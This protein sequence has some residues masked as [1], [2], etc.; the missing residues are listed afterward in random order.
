MGWCF[1]F[2]FCVQFLLFLWRSRKLPEQEPRG[3]L[4]VPPSSPCAQA[5]QLG[6]SRHRLGAAGSAG[7]RSRAANVPLLSLPV[8]HGWEV[9]VKAA[10]RGAS[11]FQPRSLAHGHMWFWGMPPVWRTR[12]A[13]WPPSAQSPSQHCRQF[14]VFFPQQVWTKYCTNY[15]CGNISLDK[16]TS[17]NLTPSNRHHLQAAIV[18]NICLS[19]KN[20]K[21]LKL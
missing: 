18:N 17:M 10:F 14:S 20:T 16:G 6:G 9:E 19:S 1:F 7:F 2:F 11:S 21:S 3:N 13:T 8:R 5:A 15:S 4:P 12:R